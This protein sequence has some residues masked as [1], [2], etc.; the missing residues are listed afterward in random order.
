MSVAQQQQR[1]TAPLTTLAGA[2]DSGAKSSHFIHIPPRA[3]PLHVKTKSGEFRTAE[4]K[5]NSRWTIS[6]RVGRWGGLLGDLFPQLTGTPWLKMR[7]FSFLRLTTNQ[8]SVLRYWGKVRFD[9]GLFTHFLYLVGLLLK[10]NIC[11]YSDLY[12]KWTHPA[13]C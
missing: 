7:S 9:L 4:K 13:L 3:V 2:E 1:L 8:K 11:S 5:T 12:W 6:L 10:H